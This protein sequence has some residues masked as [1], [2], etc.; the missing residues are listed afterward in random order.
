M[1]PAFANASSNARERV[2]LGVV[3][4]VLVALSSCSMYLE[5]GICVASFAICRK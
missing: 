3:I 5:P 1:V 4:F 2:T